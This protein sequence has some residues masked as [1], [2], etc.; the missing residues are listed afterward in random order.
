MKKRLPSLDNLSIISARCQTAGRGQGDHTWYSSE[1]TNLTFSILFRFPLGSPYE[2]KAKDGVIVTQISTLALCD[3][4]QTKGIS[5][6]IKWPNDIWVG[7]RKI[8]GMLIE[9]TVSNGLIL[10]SISGIGLNVNEISW[11]KELPNPV[12]MKELTEETYVLE[13]EMEEV[14]YCLEKRF[15]SI[16]SESG[17]E[18]LSKD[19]EKLVFRL[20]K[21]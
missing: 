6:R 7:K 5:A 9:N 17:R 21:D 3:Y 13:K 14:A 1:N 8:S 20:K 2:L 18:G 15:R 12:S 4:L 10:N 11:P 19:F 16:S